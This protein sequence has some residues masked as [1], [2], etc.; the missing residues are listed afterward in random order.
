MDNSEAKRLREALGL[1]QGGLAKG[2]GI[3]K[4]T[5]SRIESGEVGASVSVA[6]KLA[7]AINAPPAVIY[8]MTQIRCIVKA[9]DE[10]DIDATSAANKLLRVLSTLLER[11]PD[12]ESADGGEE[13]LDALEAALEE[14]TADSVKSVRA[15]GKED[16]PVAT[17]N[18]G[19]PIHGAFKAAFDRAGVGKDVP[20]AEDY[21]VDDDRDLTGRALNT[22]RLRD[23]QEHEFPD[24]DSFGTANE[25]AEDDFPTDAYEDGRDVFGRR[26]RPLTRPMNGRR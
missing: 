3:N 18:S 21:D 16:A 11:F 26:S 12:V 24:V 22:A 23:D 1:S 14:Q 4:A 5:M 25:Y 17:K 7:G 15:S 2:S 19:P 8:G 10:G 9:V 13:L 20:R 6:L